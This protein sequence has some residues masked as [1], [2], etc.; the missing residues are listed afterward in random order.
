MISGET[1]S[2]VGDA[3]GTRANAG[4]GKCA[5]TVRGR[6]TKVFRADDQNIDLFVHFLKLRHF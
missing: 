3:A 5:Q 4:S 6:I 1:G 2:M